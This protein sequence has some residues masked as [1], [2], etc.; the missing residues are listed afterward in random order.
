MATPTLRALRDHF[1]DAEIVG[2]FRP[3]VADVLAGTRL[4]DRFVIH[5][6]K[7]SRW[8]AWQ[9]LQTLRR[10]RFDLAVVLPNSLRTGIWAWASG[11]KR[12]LGYARDGRGLL[13]TDPV[14]AP[15]QAIPHPVLD[16]MLQLVG[17][18]G[19]RSLSRKMELATLPQDEDHLAA[20][21]RRHAAASSADYI[22]L[23]TGGA[24]GAA[25]D[26]PVEY[27]SELSRRLAVEFDGSVLIACG[28][29]ERSIAQ[30]IVS[31]A[32]HPRVLS[33]A[34]EPLSIG[35]TKAAVRNARLLVT[36]DS[37]PRHFAAAFGVPCLTLFGPTHI[38]WSETFHPLAVHLQRKVDCGPCQQRVCPLQHHRCMRE[39]TVD[40]V[41]GEIVRRWRVLRQ[42]KEFGLCTSAAG[43]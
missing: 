6:P 25:K 23:N 36:T 5:N 24:F 21:W 9:M 12:T 3:Y 27:F 13:L 28:P 39:L 33:L 15:S 22:C 7:Q 20:F 1:A 14:P 31:E 29:Q 32:A 19:C 40:Q 10:E 41:F 4:I 8:D 2:I 34:N 18:L 17:Q 38:A 30:Q 11:A 26:W 16:E 35:L 42:H 37:G 43:R